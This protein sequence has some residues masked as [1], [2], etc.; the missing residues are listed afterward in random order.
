MKKTD[1]VLRLFHRMIYGINEA[2]QTYMP[3]MGYPD[4]VT[5]LLWPYI[6]LILCGTAS[7]YNYVLTNPIRLLFLSSLVLLSNTTI[8]VQVDFL[9]R[10]ICPSKA[11][12]IISALG[13]NWLTISSTLARSSSEVRGPV[14]ITN[15]SSA[16]EA[17][18][19]S[20]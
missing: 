4:E 10:R 5:F 16:S 6:L 17:S 20:I 2:W 1:L 9:R 13:A 8:Q 14:R 3:S 12:R 19:T 18:G 7:K 15:C 11:L